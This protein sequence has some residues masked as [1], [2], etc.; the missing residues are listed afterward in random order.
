MSTGHSWLAGLT[1]F[2][3]GWLPAGTVGCL[4]TTALRSLLPLITFGLL[5]LRARCSVLDLID[6]LLSSRANIVHA[7]GL[8]QYGLLC[9]VMIG[10]LYKRLLSFVFL[11]IV[12]NDVEHLIPPLF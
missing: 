2:L 12:S 3:A 8:G 5:A 1:G 7:A 9:L 4:P 10:G 6:L 11:V